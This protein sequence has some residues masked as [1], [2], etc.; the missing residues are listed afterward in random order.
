MKSA[1]KVRPIKSEEDYEA[2]LGEIEKLWD[3]KPETPNGD[4][5]DILSTLVEKYEEEHF[6]IEAPNP[7]E[8]IKFRMEQLG[9]N[10]ARLGEII[11]GRNRATE[12]LNKERRL[13]VSMIRSLNKELSIPAE[14]LIQEYR[15]KK[16]K[17]VSRPKPPGKARKKKS[18][19][20]K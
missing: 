18:S 15:L 14:S 12:I 9:I 3:A 17:P 13:T 19:T 7:I 4:M 20:A 16:N 2:A 8:A 1:L 10:K 11:G 6:P 5:L